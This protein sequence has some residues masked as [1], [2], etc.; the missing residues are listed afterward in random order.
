MKTVVDT[1][2]LLP[3]LVPAAP[4]LAGKP[5]PGDLA[6]RVDL[7]LATAWEMANVRPAAPAGDAA[8]ARRAYLDLVGR[9][10][11]AAEARDF[12]DDRSPDKR[13]KL[14]A[15][16]IDSPAHARHA[17][18]FW[19]REW[20]PQADTPQFAPLA[21]DVEPW[22]A[23]RLRENRG[24]DR[25]AHDLL[26]ANPGKA[27]AGPAPL[28]FLAAGEYKPELLA[29]NTARA[30]LGVNLD[31]AQCH[32]HP[33][34]RW[35]RDQFWQTAAFFARPR[36]AGGD[37]SP[38]LE[39]TVPS[40]GKAVAPRLL[41]G[42]PPTWPKELGPDTGRFLLARWV[43]ARDNPYFAKNAVNR[44]WANLFGTGLV[45]P[46]DD[47]SGDNPPS[48][49]ALLDDLAKAFADSGFDLRYLTTA[50][51]RTKAYQFASA[52]PR[53]GSDDPRLF[54]RS[55]VRGLTG[56]QLYDSLR[57]AAGLAA[58]RPDLDP[59][60]AFRQRK[61]FA[62]KF[63]LERPAAAGRSILQSLS[64]MN[65]QFTRGL[66]VADA[67]TL[68]AVAGSP[69]LDTR[70][71]VEALY[72][73]ALGRKPAAEEAAPVVEYVEKGGADADAKAALA[74]V[75]WALLNSSEFSTNH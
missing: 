62:E 17:A 44:A 18:T 11:T 7:H 63:R 46:L 4:A 58:E 38:R 34:A 42:G 51:A 26:T 2:V 13:S 19:R 29:A 10:P 14:A 12:L 61:E 28:A 1:L 6:A 21:D 75:F 60:E 57:V 70:G 56:E 9:V 36:A 54:A 40:S 8:F 72:M 59:M 20:L 5:D 32:N 43:T 37:A 49:P 69:F 68:R 27:R 31:C 33:F 16:L 53:G 45:E 50:L 23:A 15:R 24:Y 41:T 71:R 30:F 64:L 25:L 74:D 47:L 65:G 67:P 35:T 3:F 55:A 22:L 48:H 73:A 52:V 66:T 39:V